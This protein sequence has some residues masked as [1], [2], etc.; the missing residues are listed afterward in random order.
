MVAPLSSF[1]IAERVG[2]G[3]VLGYAAF[4]EPELRGAMHRLGRV[5]REQS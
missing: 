4:D 5:L 2:P 3:L 1:A